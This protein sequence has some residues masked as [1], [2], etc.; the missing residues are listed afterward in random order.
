MLFLVV[1]EI[2]KSS[3][4]CTLS[5]ESRLIIRSRLRPHCLRELKCDNLVVCLDVLSAEDV[6]G[7]SF[8]SMSLDLLRGTRLV[9]T[10]EEVVTSSLLKREIKRVA[11]ISK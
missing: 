4:S 3:I 6:V 7:E 2:L 8:L 11:L 10:V 1:S 9:V 5:F